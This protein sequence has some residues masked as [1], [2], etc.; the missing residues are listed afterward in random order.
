[1]ADLLGVTRSGYYAWAARQGT[2]PGPRAAR[3]ADLVVK[4]KVAHDASDGVNGAPRVTAGLREA[5]E[6]VSVKTVA[7]LM[8]ENDIRGI[9]P[10]R[11]GRSPPSLTR[12]RTQSRTW[13]SAASTKAL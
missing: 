10:R 6:V 3:R 7:K 8:R 9:S 5:G 4:I 1:M 2:A 12:A 11:G 13:F